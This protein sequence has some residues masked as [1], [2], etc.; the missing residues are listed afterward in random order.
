MT[1]TEF[2]FLDLMMP[3]ITTECIPTIDTQVLVPTALLNMIHGVRSDLDI[4]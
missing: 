2:L 4:R 3:T 1:Q